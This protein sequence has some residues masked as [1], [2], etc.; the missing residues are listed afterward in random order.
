MQACGKYPG[1]VENQQIAGI[2]K[3]AQLGKM[4]VNELAAFPADNEQARV[5][6]IAAGKC[7]N[8]GF[9]EVIRKLLNIHLN[10][11][12]KH[13]LAKAILN[14]RI[15]IAAPEPILRLIRSV[16]KRRQ[17]IDGHRE[18]GCRILF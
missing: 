8:E 16:E 18:D 2:E 6:P 4:R 15:Q 12:A 7:R 3:I 1:I 10:G 5:F 9:G 14:R 17:Q 11:A 13:Y